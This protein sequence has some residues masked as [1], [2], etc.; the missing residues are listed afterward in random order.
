M[1]ERP[2]SL[3]ELLL[4]AGII[5]PGSDPPLRLVSAKCPRCGFAQ[6][7]VVPVHH[8]AHCIEPSCG[9]DLEPS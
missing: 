9:A 6:N 2:A 1:A 3:R 5:G 4:E 7:I 8:T